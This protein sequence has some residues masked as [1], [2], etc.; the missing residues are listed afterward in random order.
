MT[1]ITANV[2]VSMPSQ[3]F[4][5]ARS[6]K[7]VANGKIYIGKIDTDPVNPENQIQV[8]VENEDGSHVPVSQPIIIN[9]AGYPVYNGQIAKFVTVQGH[10]M[11][12]YDAYGA[13]QFYFPNV[14]KY[15][16]DQFKDEV[17][18]KINWV[19]PEQFGAKGDALLYIDNN[20]DY[21][22]NPDATD[23]TVA[24]RAAIETG[25]H[26]SFDG[27]KG[28]LISDIFDNVKSGQAISGNGAK[29]VYRGGKPPSSGIYR[30]IG[31][32]QPTGSFDTYDVQAVAA[33]NANTLKE[34]IDVYDNASLKLKR[35]DYFTLL[36]DNG[37]QEA[38][39]ETR[40]KKYVFCMPRVS[41]ITNNEDG[42]KRL[43]MSYKMGYTFTPEQ[44]TIGKANPLTDIHISGF[45]LIDEQVVTPTEFLPSGNAIQAPE[46]E[47][48]VA[49]GLF[50]A[51]CTA[52]LTVEDLT[53]Y[54]IKWPLCSTMLSHSVSYNKLRVM[55]TDW[56]GGGEGYCV[57]MNW[58]TNFNVKDLIL[59]QGRHVFDTTACSWGTVIG[60][61]SYED[62]Y[63]I[64][65]HT[66]CDHDITYIGCV[67]RGAGFANGAF[68]K[69]TSRLSFIDCKFDR[70]AME[71]AMYVTFT[72]CFLNDIDVSGGFIS[73]V[74]CEVTELRWLRY[75]SRTGTDEVVNR[76]AKAGTLSVD[77]GTRL[78]K[79][80][81]WYS[82][83]ALR[84]WTNVYID[85]LIEA[86][87]EDRNPA[88]NIDSVSRF[89]LSGELKNV[90]LIFQGTT[91]Y[92]QIIGAKIRHTRSDITTGAVLN[93]GI[94]TP[95]GVQYVTIRDNHFQLSG[96]M[97]PY[98]IAS[99]ESNT[100]VLSMS[101][102]IGGNNQVGG[103]KG[104]IND[105]NGSK[106]SFN[107]FSYTKEACSAS[108]TPEISVSRDDV[109]YKRGD[110][111]LGKGVGGRPAVWNPDS[112]TWIT[113]N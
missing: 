15:D 39:Y 63:G 76:F 105:Y 24:I 38:D 109:R 75:D 112:S 111:E 48:E 26:V 96:T 79:S 67:A 5:M 91:Q 53:G 36:C 88:W 99:N 56:S 3:L 54:T 113:L 23:D 62:N 70:V 18:K 83:F 107:G 4:T 57:S 93:W 52:N 108:L 71:G 29:I 44:I 97:Q 89:K 31:V 35:G 2:V 19:T 46:S 50:K 106:L 37:V 72:N 1:D 11:A 14:L 27:S 92:I 30:R 20:G 84:G 40:I 6:F 98:K 47:R 45:V 69:V 7:A 58:C 41:K 81:T 90:Q 103:T 59:S 21:V 87:G 85:G 55:S 74:G 49:I 102:S 77:S 94:G 34:Y 104:V 32:F 73:F 66:T 13:Q 43:W 8:Y 64:T 16:P 100:S 9:A 12:V 17:E 61:R 42:T 22:T 82:S 65:S 10:S 80:G 78:L 25:K 51:I 110:V 60:A 33:R 101:L 28:Y 95:G 68:G 86:P